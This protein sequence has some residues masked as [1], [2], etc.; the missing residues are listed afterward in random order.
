MSEKKRAT[1]LSLPG[2]ETVISYWLLR[3]R[4]S[5]WRFSFKIYLPHQTYALQ[6]K[7]PCMEIR[8]MEC[9][10]AHKYVKKCT[11]AD[12]PPYTPYFWRCMRAH[13]RL[14]FSLKFICIFEC[15]YL[16]VF[17]TMR[18][19]FRYIFLLYV[20]GKFINGIPLILQKWFV[21]VG[22]C[23]NVPPILAL[24]GKEDYSGFGG[25][26]Y[27]DCISWDKYQFATE[28]QVHQIFY[29]NS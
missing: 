17:S 24:G 19:Q 11:V 9:K 16:A 4:S 14:I 25:Y 21:L 6:I 8:L 7:L 28:I 10:G 13:C 18:S 29:R 2:E 22:S 15:T 1:P 23:P 27:V 3:L 12:Q 20:T 26:W 5:F